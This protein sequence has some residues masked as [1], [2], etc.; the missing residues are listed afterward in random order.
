MKAENGLK[1]PSSELCFGILNEI[2]DLYLLNS[3]VASLKSGQNGR[4]L[5]F[6]STVFENPYQRFNL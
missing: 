1:L 3:K 6:F 2:K 5:S 4:N